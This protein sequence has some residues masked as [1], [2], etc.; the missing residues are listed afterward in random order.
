MN[1]DHALRLDDETLCDEVW[2]GRLAHPLFSCE[3]KITG[4][5]RVRA[6]IKPGDLQIITSTKAEMGRHLAA[7]LSSIRDR[8]KQWDEK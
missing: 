6:T 3:L 4:S 8:I 2:A 1:I 7:H 5:G